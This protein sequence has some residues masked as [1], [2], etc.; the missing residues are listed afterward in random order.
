M[1]MK[2][3]EPGYIALVISGPCTGEQCD[4]LCWVNDGDSFKADGTYYD[5]QTGKSGWA[6]DF[7]DGCGVFETKR[8]L[9]IDGGDELVEQEQ[10]EE[11]AA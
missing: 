10:H 8:L 11:Q 9:R 6:V 7:G 4:V 3:I 1:S 5:N 2:P